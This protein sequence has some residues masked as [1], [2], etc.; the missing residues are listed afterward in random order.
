MVLFHC[1]LKIHLKLN[2]IKT[3]VVLLSLRKWKVSVSLCGRPTL[4][5]DIPSLYMCACV[6][7]GLQ[8]CCETTLVS[9]AC[10]LTPSALHMKGPGC[11]GGQEKERAMDVEDGRGRLCI[12]LHLVGICVVHWVHLLRITAWC[13]PFLSHSLSLLL[14][15]SRI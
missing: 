12:Y 10:Q 6:V 4:H 3:D 14:S 1:L 13:A 5:G 2:L 7:M 15:H 11:V 8:D 9:L